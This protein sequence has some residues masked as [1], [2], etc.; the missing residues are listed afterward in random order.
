M[1]SKLSFPKDFLWGAATAAYQI[2]GAWNEDN[3]GPSIW[4]TFSHLPG[5]T[6]KGQTG[7]VAAD[8]YHRWKADVDLMKTLGIH[9]D[10][11]LGIVGQ[12]RAREGLHCRLGRR[13]HVRP[14][15][16]AIVGEEVPLAVRVLFQLLRL[17]AQ[18]VRRDARD[19]R[20]P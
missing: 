10:D 8:H 9:R 20:A 5:K 2:E 7:D 4:D 1:D 12:Q 3:K 19:R 14:S 17:E 6:F 11:R 15:D 18:E 13:L 16:E